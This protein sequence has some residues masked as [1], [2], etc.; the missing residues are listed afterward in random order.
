MRAAPPVTFAFVVGSLVLSLAAASPAAVP[1]G[2]TD[3]LVVGVAAPTDV[4][5]TPDG[6]ILVTSQGGT[7]SV[8]DGTGA[9]LGS[10]TFPGAQLCS[11]SERGLLGVAV[12][13]NHAVNRYVYL[14]YTRRKPSG[15]C[16]TAS[17]ITSLTAVNAVV[18]LLLA[19]GGEQGAAGLDDSDQ[20][21]RVEDVE[22]AD[23][24]GHQRLLALQGRRQV[25]LVSRAGLSVTTD[26]GGSLPSPSSRAQGTDGLWRLSSTS[27]DALRDC[28]GRAAS[29]AAAPWR[30]PSR[31]RPSRRRAPSGA[32]GR[33]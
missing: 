19:E 20:D 6:R 28:P 29:G 27:L 33:R 7:L 2:F 31:G 30:R 17:P 18:Q 23:Q 14:F 32:G 13:P 24:P 10:Q 1:A 16:S 21:G 25:G 15:D 5:F 12:D 9:L 4:A 26:V 22:G 3:T 11:N 8:Y